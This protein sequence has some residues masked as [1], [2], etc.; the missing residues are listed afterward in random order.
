MPSLKRVLVLSDNS[1]TG[2][3]LTA[4]IK[5]EIEETDLPVEIDF[6]ITDS[7]EDY[8]AAVLKAPDDGYDTLYPVALRLHDEAGATFTAKEILLWTGEHSSLPSIPLNFAFVKLGLFGGAGVGKTDVY[9][10]I[11]KG[12]QEALCA[13]HVHL[14]VP[15]ENPQC[16]AFALEVDH[17]FVYIRGEY[18]K[19][20]RR[21]Q[22][23]IDEAYSRGMVV[24]FPSGTYLISDTLNCMKKAWCIGHSPP[25]QG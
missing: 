24:F 16:R 2:V 13:V 4:Q 8:R 21:L 19:P 7:L 18:P 17:A 3:A 23:A 10:T 14:T 25:G 5:S 15:L 9:A 22:R 12:L 6:H 1:P 11:Y 20:A